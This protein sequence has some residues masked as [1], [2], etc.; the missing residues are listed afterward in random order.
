MCEISIKNKIEKNSTYV[1]Q[2][3]IELVSSAR[4]AN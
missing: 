2:T 1:N 3:F 4:N